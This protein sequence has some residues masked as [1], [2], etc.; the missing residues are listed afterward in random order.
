MSIEY[1]VLSIVK[2]FEFLSIL[3][4]LPDSKDAYIVGGTVR[5]M[6]I[7][8][9]PV[10]V[11]IVVSGN[12]G[13]FA[14]SILKKIDGTLFLLDK[15]RGVFRIATRSESP[16]FYYDISPM[17]GGDIF[18]DLSFRDFTI[19]ALAIQLSCMNT[20]IDPYSGEADIRRGCIKVISRKSFEDDPLRM[21][22]AF[23]LAS[24]LRFKIDTDTLIA[25]QGMSSSLRLAARER[26][27]DEFF[28]ILSSPKS[29]QYL[30]HMH[31][32]GLLKVILTGL[33]EEGI[34][35]GLKV[36]ERLEHLYNT[37]QDI[38][39]PYHVDVEKYLLTRIEEGITNATL[40]KWIALYIINNINGELMRNDLEGLRLGNKACRLALLGFKHGQTCIPDKDI[41]DIEDKRS[42]YHFFKATGDDGIGLILYQLA[43]FATI[44]EIYDTALRNARFAISWYLYEYKK[45]K[46]SPLITGDDLTGLFQIAPGPVFRR[47]LDA[48]EENRA[49]GILST[50][51][52]AISF[53]KKLI[54]SF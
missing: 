2:V 50:R 24:T 17:R 20:I 43:S 4:N 45:M 23:R 42:I 12:A 7:G 29:I 35:E 49:I 8:K 27:R 14:R 3:R 52:D 47:L 31:N 19:D 18:T 54:T 39:S 41:K 48:V 6:I 33:D 36:F 38:F 15:E 21:L 28:R 53:L 1:R 30:N 51:D 13:R 11:D 16:P 34:R 22:R 10:D 37:L 5:D 46:V 44:R 26:I 9:D 40:W 25:I 32:T